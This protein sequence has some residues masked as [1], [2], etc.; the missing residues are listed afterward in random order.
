MGESELARLVHFDIPTVKNIV[1]ATMF[2]LDV[3]VDDFIVH[4]FAHKLRL[5]VT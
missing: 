3:L 5:K 4:P 1:L 2:L